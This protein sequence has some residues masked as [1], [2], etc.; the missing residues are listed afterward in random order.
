M[1]L[2]TADDIN[3]HGFLKATRELQNISLAA[4]GRGLYSASMMQRIEDGERLPKKL[5]R[6]RIVARLGVSG[7]RYEDYLPIDEYEWWKQRQEIVKAVE[8]KKWR[9]LNRLLKEYKTNEKHTKVDKQFIGAMRFMLLQGKGASDE[10]LH[11]MI[12]EIVAYTIPRMHKRFPQYLLLSAQEVNL[13]MEYIRLHV[14][15]D[16]YTKFKRRRNRITRYHH[17]FR[18]IEQ[19]CMDD[20]EKS[21]VYPKLVYYVCKEYADGVGSI[22]EIFHALDL[23]NEAIELL[24]NKKRMYYLIELL[25]C[26]QD[27]IA[28]ILAAK[29]AGNEAVM[30]I[31]VEVLS[32]LAKT[33]KEWEMM[34]KELYAEYNMSPYMENFCY[35]YWETESY[36]VNDIIRIRRRMLGMTQEEL[37]DGI[38]SVKTLGRAENKRR[39]LQM[40]EVRRIFAKLGLC[41]EYVR[42]NVIT[43][44]PEVMRLHDEASRYAN[45]HDIEMWKCSL[46]ELEARLTTDIVQN[47][48]ILIRHHIALAVRTGEMSKE[49]SV[50]EIE[51]SLR[52]TMPLEYIE[53]QTECYLTREEILSVH[54]MAIKCNSKKWNKYFEILK[55]F[56][57]QQIEQNSI[58]MRIGVHEILMTTIANHLG[59]LGKIR[60]SNKYG[61]YMIK[62]G[63]E[64]R[65]MQALAKNLYHNCWNIY[66]IGDGER[67]ARDNQDVINCLNRCILL[68]EIVG[69]KQ[70]KEFFVRMSQ[71]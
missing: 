8:A 38:C 65:R 50:H 70:L 49:Q 12:E 48:Q 31:D 25:E 41:P 1:S 36:C 39:C 14:S 45:A 63:L 32:A 7:D 64:N 69:D 21:K 67:L 16:N 6:D 61:K 37:A 62:R 28:R 13:F 55:K 47:K 44:D 22:E 26:R 18:Y 40:Y 71:N 3:F 57:E 34:F 2:Y 24:R 30:D 19:S 17:I 23:C 11:E 35:L 60:E 9:S 33:S 43:S 27:F 29:E 54:N 66:K 53:G 20:L 51:K 5:E 56:C 46:E 68:S 4:L 58:T 42:A 15:N 10:K 59:T 52:L